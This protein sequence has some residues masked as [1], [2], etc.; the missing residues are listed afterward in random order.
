[1]ST[2]LSSYGVYSYLFPPHVTAAAVIFN[3]YYVTGVWKGGLRIRFDIGVNFGGT[4]FFDI[5]RTLTNAVSEGWVSQTQADGLPVTSVSMYCYSD[6]IVCCFYDSNGDVAGVQVA[7]PKDKFTPYYKDMDAVGFTDWTV[8]DVEYYTLQQY[9]TTEVLF[10]FHFTFESLVHKTIS[11]YTR[12][13]FVERPLHTIEHCAL[14]FS[15]ILSSRAI[16]RANENKIIENGGVWLVGTNKEVVQVSNTTNEL[17]SE[18]VFTKQACIPWMGRH[19]YYKMDPSLSCDEPIFPWFPIVESGELVATG[20]MVFGVLNLDSDA[21]NW[22]EHPSESAVKAIV[23]SGPDC[24]YALA[25]SP[26]VVTMHIYYIDQ[27]WLI[28]CIFQ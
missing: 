1:M 20:L 19:Y 25:G 15:E 6:N 10:V 17:V 5:P 12:D 18:G 21:R 24:L 9:F 23:T 3:F 11:N 16:T 8:D 26:G 4:F 27:P 13:S 14:Y 28:S 22:F 7:L 2:L